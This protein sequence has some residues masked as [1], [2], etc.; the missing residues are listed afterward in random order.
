MI[1]VRWF[2]EKPIWP[3]LKCFVGGLFFSLKKFYNKCSENSRSQIVFG[4]YIFRKLTLGA[5]GDFLLRLS[6]NL[7]SINPYW[8]WVKC[9]VAFLVLTREKTGSWEEIDRLQK[10]QTIQQTNH[11]CNYN[12]K[13]STGDMK[14]KTSVVWVQI[15]FEAIFK[16]SNVKS[17]IQSL[18][19]MP[20]V[21]PLIGGDGEA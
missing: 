6:T 10:P 5:P 15:M 19:W 11:S 2:G 1:E 20:E 7:V 21:S 8:S 9:R 13:Q 4:I 14:A 18:S 17:S 16:R 12:G 3:E